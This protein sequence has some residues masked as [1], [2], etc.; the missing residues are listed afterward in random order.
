MI[1]ADTDRRQLTEIR[2]RHARRSARCA[3]PDEI[4]ELLE[5]CEQLMR[6]VARML[7]HNTGEEK[8]TP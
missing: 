7:G 4:V 6:M 1:T 3:T 5:D 8:N 2:A